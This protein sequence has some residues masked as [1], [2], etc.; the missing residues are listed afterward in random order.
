MLCNGSY[1][2]TN[3]RVRG[4][5]MHQHA[6]PLAGYPELFLIFA[7][8]RFL[9]FFLLHLVLHFAVKPSFKTSVKYLCRGHISSSCP[10]SLII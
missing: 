9:D 5:G 3:S 1:N 8:L 2:S 7:L 4:S 10:I 6:H